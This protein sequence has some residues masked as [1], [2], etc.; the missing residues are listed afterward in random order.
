[1]E[2]LKT[3]IENWKMMV[4]RLAKEE[5]ENNK[6]TNGSWFGTGGKKEEVDG[7]WVRE[8]MVLEEREKRAKELITSLRLDKGVGGAFL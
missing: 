3:G 1:M 5:R 4:R 2:C 7:R 8:E 6:T